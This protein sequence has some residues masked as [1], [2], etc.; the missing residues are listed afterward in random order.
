MA[1]DSKHWTRRDFMANGGKAAAGLTAASVLASRGKVQAAPAITDNVI[2]ANGR[3]NMAIIGTGGRGGGLLSSFAKIP[4][5]HIKTI[6]DVDENVFP[7]RVKKVKDAH[8]YAPGTEWDMRKVFDD[9]DI[10]AVAIARVLPSQDDD[11]QRANRHHRSR[12]TRPA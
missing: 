8:G 7:S 1:S 3:I 11:F 5:I 10:D 2:G 4:N 9:P 6:C 12:A